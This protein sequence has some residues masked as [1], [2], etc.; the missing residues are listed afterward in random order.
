MDRPV[1]KAMPRNYVR[2]AFYFAPEADSALGRFG[3]AWLGFDPSTGE[4]LPRPEV[5]GMGS[6]E[7]ARITES[8]SR[9]GFHGTLIPSCVNNDS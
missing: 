9:Y 7:I 8:P 2:F 1:R 3:N 4:D 6:D 5:N